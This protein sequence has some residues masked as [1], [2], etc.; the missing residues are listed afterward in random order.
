MTHNFTNLLSTRILAII[1]S[2]GLLL[3]ALPLA[4][5]HAQEATGGA[6]GGGV[7]QPVPTYD[8]VLEKKIS[9]NIPNAPYL[10][11][12]FSFRVTGGG[13]NELVTLEFGT[14]DYAKKVIQ[15]PVGVYTIEE[16]GPDDFVADDWT[17]QWSGY[18]CDNYNGPITPTTLT[19]SDDVTGNVCRADNQYR[20]APA[21]IPGCTDPDADNYDPAAEEN[22]GSCDYGDDDVPGCTEPDA[23]N[24]N[25]DATVDDGSCDYGG[26]DDDDDDDDGNG[27]CDN[28][29]TATST[30]KVFGYV[31]HDE[32]SNKLWDGVDNDEATTT[33]EDLPT[34]TVK[35]TD[36]VNTYATTTD[37]D[38]YY[39][40]WVPAGTWT[41][42][43]DVKSGWARTFPD[44]GS[45]VVVV[46]SS[47]QAA[48]SAFFAQL[49][50]AL[51]PT[52]HAQTPTMYGPFNFGNVTGGTV[53]PSGGPRPGGG[54][55]GPRC[56]EFTAD[57]NGATVLLAW[58]TSRG[59]E[60][61]ITADGVEI[62]TTTDDDVV[63]EGTFE[64]SYNGNVR[65]ELTVERGSRDDTCEASL[66]SGGGSD[67][68]RVLGE[69]VS[70]IP[71]GSANAGAGGAAP[72]SFPS[73]APFVAAVVSLPARRR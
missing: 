48:S 67:S 14:K 16:I 68:G 2:I 51:I 42:T 1:A 32:N 37:E 33:E 44:S 55:S 63:D 36:G 25:P 4:F 26:G 71:L 23:D 35:I 72:L 40:F 10:P 52:A 46:G 61:F 49:K 19:V 20:G 45:H 18:A 73:P 54:S 39:E 28:D 43:E 47:A 31:W 21:P 6:G 66:T 12:D 9:D 13:V 56:R 70:A 60:M 50:R 29:C 64:A 38:G 7:S 58:E 57:R 41:I 53:T 24:Y 8:V 65:Y 5:A 59:T 11:T 69:Q 30:W 15:L 62:F 3:L 34:W 27:N 17:V 22:D